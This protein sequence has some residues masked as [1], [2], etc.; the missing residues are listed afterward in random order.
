MPVRARLTACDEP[1]PVPMAV[2]RLP[3]ILTLSAMDGVV[4]H[5]VRKIRNTDKSMDGRK[6]GFIVC[7]LP[8]IITKT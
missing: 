4:V 7:L 2:V 8:G 6:K 5:P 3:S 1:L